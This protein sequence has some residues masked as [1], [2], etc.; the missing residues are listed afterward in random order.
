MDVR[1]Q[2]KLIRFYPLKTLFGGFQQ[3]FFSSFSAWYFVN[4]YVSTSE[5]QY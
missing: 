2:V 5:Y 1:C 3:R 4:E